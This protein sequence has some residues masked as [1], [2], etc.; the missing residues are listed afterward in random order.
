M[1]LS[2]F[3]GRDLRIA[4]RE[5]TDIV[6]PVAFF[7]LAITVYSIGTGFSTNASPI[8]G[9]GAIWVLALFA[10]LLGV[11][12]MYRRDYVDGTL[13]VFLLHAQPLPICILV[14]VLAHWGV[15]VL[16]LV[17]FSPIAGWMMGIESNALLPL[18]VSLMLG[19]PALVLLGA[20][21]SAL[22]LGLNRGSA[23]L[24]LL[25]LP[26]YVPILILGLSLATAEWSGGNSLGLLLWLIALLS[27]TMTFS[28]F[29]IALVLKSSVEY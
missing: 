8:I 24:V 10:T 13:E 25:I 9:A 23:L 6:H 5:R 7:L 29:A 21:G 1:A 11:E 16:P 17:L 26:L 4:I 12:G 22:V 14:R 27:A 20:M 15:S 28:P 3:M 2:G 18:F 19:T